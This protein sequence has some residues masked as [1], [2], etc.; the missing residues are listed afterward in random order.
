MIVY[1]CLCPRVLDVP[2]QTRLPDR[3]HG[4]AGARSA[5]GRAGDLRVV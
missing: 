3:L 2:A 1:I 5:M 4:A